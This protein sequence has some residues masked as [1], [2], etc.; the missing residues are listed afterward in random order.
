MHKH[1][2]VWVNESVIEVYLC[3]EWKKQGNIIFL[4]HIWQPLLYEAILVFNHTENE[5]LY[6]TIC[7]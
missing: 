3:E 1:V 2:C 5:H 7:G 4:G 6:H